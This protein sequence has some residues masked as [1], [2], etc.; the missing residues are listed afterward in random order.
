M[1]RSSFLFLLTGILV[2]S[3][4]GCAGYLQDRLKDASEIVELGVGYSKGLTLN[5]RATKLAQVGVGSYSGDWAGLREGCLCTWSE[6][7]TEFGLTPFLYHEVFRKSDR[8]VDIRHPLMWDPGY[9]T[10][11]NDLFLVTDRGFFEVGVTANIVVF[12][13][14]A[15][16]ELAEVADFLTGLVGID[17]LED[18]AYDLPPEKLVKRLQSRNAWRR[19]AAVRALR[20]VAGRDADGDRVDFGYVLFTVADEHTEAQIQCWR[21]WKAWLEESR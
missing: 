1:K 21:L 13:V 17:L 12:G 16:V 5:L 15:A 3:T 6:E 8:L 10:F 18:D 2:V 9:E 7:R 19:Y 20:R 4:C 14:D 11:L